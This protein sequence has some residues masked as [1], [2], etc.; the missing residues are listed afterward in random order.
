MLSF[1]PAFPLSSF[2][3]IKK[4]FSSSSLSVTRVISAGVIAH[5]QL[6]ILLALVS[7]YNSCCP[8]VPDPVVS[9]PPD[10]SAPILASL[11]SQD[12]RQTNPLKPVRGY[13]A[14]A[15]NLQW[16]PSLQEAK[17][18]SS[19]WAHQW[20]T[21]APFPFCPC[22]LQPLPHS[23]SS[24][25]RKFLPPPF[26]FHRTLSSQL[27]TTLLPPDLYWNVTLALR[28]LPWQPPHWPSSRHFLSPS[29]ALFFCGLPITI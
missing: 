5:S 22:F 26:P 4:L 3:L 14:C 11:H 25:L 29:T 9:V 12:S 18:R 23:S 28:S 15:H 27:A 7:K 10:V 1:K 16:L 13:Y 19:A 2:I 6:Q 21:S 17:Q 8:L 20:M 24:R